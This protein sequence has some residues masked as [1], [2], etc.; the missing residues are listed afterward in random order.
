MGTRV[1]FNT[2]GTRIY[3]PWPAELKVPVHGTVELNH[4][5]HDEAVILLAWA[6]NSAP[7]GHYVS[8]TYTNWEPGLPREQWKL[9]VT[10]TRL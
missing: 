3:G 8:S 6:R 7:P 4:Q 10:Y 2:D 1:T 9:Q 5:T